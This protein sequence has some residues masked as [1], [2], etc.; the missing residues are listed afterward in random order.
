MA[1]PTDAEIAKL[2]E[3]LA[4]L[5]DDERE[6]MIDALE[7]SILKRVKELITAAVKKEEPPEK[8]KS[9]LERLG[10]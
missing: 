3:R 8:A 9:F 4:S 2:K 1:K 7:P 6:A 10:F 5:T